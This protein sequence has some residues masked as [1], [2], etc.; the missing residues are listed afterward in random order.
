MGDL[1][2]SRA[3]R[4]IERD[5]LDGHPA[6]VAAARES[7]NWAG[8]IAQVYQHQLELGWLPPRLTVTDGA[9]A[10]ELVLLEERMG[11]L[12]CASRS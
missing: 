5:F 12:R 6:P 7:G 11:V 9:I 8:S 3:L 10:A 1:V 2:S 4:A